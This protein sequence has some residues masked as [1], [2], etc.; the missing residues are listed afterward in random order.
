LACRLDGNR[1]S[2]HPPTNNYERSLHAWHQ[3]FVAAFRQNAFFI[4][5]STISR[6]LLAKASYES[7]KAGNDLL[8]WHRPAID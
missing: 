1:Q 3:L 6:R 5:R 8:N 2:D 4:R 7:R